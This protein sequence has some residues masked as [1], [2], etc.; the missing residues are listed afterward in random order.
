MELPYTRSFAATKITTLFALGLSK[1]D[2]NKHISGLKTILKSND[3]EKYEKAY[4]AVLSFESMAENA[5]DAIKQLSSLVCVYNLLDDEPIDSFD[6]NLQIKKMAILEADLDAQAFFL[7]RQ[8][9]ATEDYM[10]RLKLLSEIVLP[11]P[12]GNEVALS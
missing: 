9:Q 3:P 5:A 7:N 1:D 4:S 10:N 12:N 6:N 11:K 8:L 2:L